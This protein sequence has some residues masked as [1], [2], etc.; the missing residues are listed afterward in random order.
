MAI[1][2]LG[3]KQLVLQHLSTGKDA[4]SYLKILA[5]NDIVLH[6]DAPDS[7]SITLQSRG[8]SI[9]AG[10]LTGNDITLSA[11]KGSLDIDRLEAQGLLRAEAE[12]M[13]FG[14]A[15]IG[16]GSIRPGREAVFDRL[17]TNGLAQ[18]HNVSQYQVYDLGDGLQLRLTAGG[19]SP[20]DALVQ[21]DNALHE[22]CSQ[23][24][25]ATGV[26]GTKLE[27]DVHE[28]LFGPQI[29]P[30]IL[31]DRYNLIEQEEAE[32]KI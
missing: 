19:R 11:R 3:D 15:S 14:D 20:Y 8:G 21:F 10:E 22:F 13:H 12:R 17:R 1:N 25:Y 9:T 4:G 26:L 31:F 16:H 5:D 30:G 2:Q 23:R 27:Y 24:L 6:G 7:E 32:E 18:F 28:K 29:R